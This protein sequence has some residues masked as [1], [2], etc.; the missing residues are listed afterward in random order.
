MAFLNELV[1]FLR[2][3]RR[4]WLRPLV[5]LALLVAGLLA[6]ANGVFDAFLPSAPEDPLTPFARSHYR[7]DRAFFNR[8]SAIRRWPLR[9]G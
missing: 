1:L 3:R 5:V 2:E 6:L 8:Y 7:Q 4:S 9:L